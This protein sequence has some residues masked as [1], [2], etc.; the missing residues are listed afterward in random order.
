MYLDVYNYPKC[1]ISK[2]EPLIFL[3]NFFFSH[4]SSY[5]SQWQL[6]L[7]SHV[8]KNIWII[9]D[10]PFFC[11]SKPSGNSLASLQNSELDHLSLYNKLTIFLMWVI[12]ITVSIVFL[13]PCFPFPLKIAATVILLKYKPAHVISLLKTIQCLPTSLK[14]KSE[15]IYIVALKYLQDLASSITSEISSCTASVKYFS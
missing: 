7:S 9:F 3:F 1:N 8:G 15:Y 14:G 4:D 2:T 12:E 6:Y 10:S 5:L 11:L 13:L